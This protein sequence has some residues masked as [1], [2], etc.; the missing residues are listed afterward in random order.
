[1][2]HP[3]AVAEIAQ[4]VDV[5]KLDHIG[6]AVPSIVDGRTFYEALGLAV[7]GIEE[8]PEQG[9]RAAFLPIGDTR[10]ELLEPLGPDTLLA[11]N[12]DRRG[13]GIHHICLCVKDL[14]ASMTELA[15]R[16][17]RLVTDQPQPG[18]H[19]ALVC[20][21]HPRSTGGVLIELCQSGEE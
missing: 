6:I 7:D 4:V 8:V 16:G 9:V 2:A 15:R 12:L 11:R 17:F 19:G 21:V 13:P 5:A 10:L 1:M 18:A 3:E 20:F 14:R